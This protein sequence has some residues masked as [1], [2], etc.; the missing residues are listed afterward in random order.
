M[1]FFYTE[2]RIEELLE[3]EIRIVPGPGGVLASIDAFKAFWKAYDF[4][5]AFGVHSPERLAELAQVYGER[6]GQSF[7][8]S[9]RDIVWSSNAE[10]RKLIGVDCF[11]VHPLPPR[12]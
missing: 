12:R 8:N 10:M 2:R 7:I 4:L 3:R 1:S 5:V 9:L 6:H 11:A